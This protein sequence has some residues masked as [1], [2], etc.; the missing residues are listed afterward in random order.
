MT[1]LWASTVDALEKLEREGESLGLTDDDASAAALGQ[2]LQRLRTW[3]GAVEEVIAEL[4]QRGEQAEVLAAAIERGRSLLEE[5]RGNLGLDTAELPR[6]FDRELARLEVRIDTTRFRSRQS[7]RWSSGRSL[8]ARPQRIDG[9]AGGVQAVLPV[10]PAVQ[11]GAAD[12]GLR[13]LPRMV[14]L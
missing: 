9:R 12:A 11:R 14:P 13:P 1:M 3:L 5:G 6:G 7:C 8:N 4:Q 10:P 2:R